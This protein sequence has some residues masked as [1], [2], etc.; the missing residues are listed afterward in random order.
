MSSRLADPD[1]ILAH[2]GKSLL[3]PMSSIHPWIWT[4]EEFVENSIEARC[5]L[6]GLHTISDRYQVFIW[7]AFMI[8]ARILPGDDVDVAS[9]LDDLNRKD[10]IRRVDMETTTFGVVRHLGKPGIPWPNEL[11]AK[12]SMDRVLYPKANRWADPRLEVT[13]AEWQRLRRFVFA[14]DDYTC[15][16]C[17]AS[18]CPLDCDHVT[19]VTRGGLTVLE[20]LVA[21]CASCNRSKSWK[22]VE[23]WRS[24]P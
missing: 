2:D 21:A 23:E 17:G 16:Y 12:A 11:S 24:R 4:S 13:F 20:N 7:D 1:R 9:M 15:R 6:I 3:P 10:L 14:R 5:L 8:K 18:D 19:P 22:T